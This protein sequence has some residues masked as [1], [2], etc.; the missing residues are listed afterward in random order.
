MTVL[1]FARRIH[2]AVT[3]AGTDITLIEGIVSRGFLGNY[4]KVQVTVFGQGAFLSFGQ[5]KFIQG[6][7]MG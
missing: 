1:L 5:A 6:T 3:V 7:R 2:G 4:S